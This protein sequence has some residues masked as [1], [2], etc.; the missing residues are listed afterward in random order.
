M[1]TRARRETQATRETGA[2]P[3]ALRLAAAAQ[4]VEAV[5]VAAGAVVAAVITADGRNF[6]LG[7]EIGLTLVAFLTAGGLVAFAVGLNRARPWSR[8]PVAV[9]QLFVGGYAW[10]LIGRHLY[11]WGVPALLL[12]V[13]CLAGLFTPASLQALNRPI[14]P[15]P[16]GTQPRT[17][18]QQAT[19]TQQPAK[20]KPARKA[21]R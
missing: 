17:S 6:Q 7:S 14:P 16:T 18:T 12:A 19:K 8:T 2:R 13:A 21:T 4:A 9:T 1:A 5:A 11:G 3:V 15:P 10:Y 20:T